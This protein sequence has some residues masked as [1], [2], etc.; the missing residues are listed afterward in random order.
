[1][2]IR[3]ALLSA[4]LASGVACFAIAAEPMPKADPAR[5]QQTAT[6]VCAACHGADGKSPTA[7]NPH[8]AG[9]VA[10]YT[11]KQLMNFKAVDGKQADRANPIMAGMVANLTP[12]D[13]RN[14]GAYYAAQ[15]PKAGVARNTET[16]EL[17][18]QIFRG[19]IV[20]QGIPACSGCHGATGAGMPAQ[21]PRLA[22]QHSEYLEAQLNAWRSGAR[23]N[24]P[25]KM[26]R[27]IAAKMSDAQIKAV[28][29]YIA[30]LR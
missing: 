18:Q 4:A 24:D 2:K 11:T 20:S 22:G 14:L 8:L 25:G 5:A 1:M 9:Q 30:G 12:E 3:Q 7:E 10:E 13:M 28:A 27:T 26:M 21:Y 19:G 23:A 15:A 16:L 29:D 17:G 6:Q